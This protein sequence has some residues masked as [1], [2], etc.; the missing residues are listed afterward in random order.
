[1]CTN[2]SDRG[3]SNAPK[4]KELRPFNILGLLKI[5][6]KSDILAFAALILSL[7]NAFI[8]YDWITRKSDSELLEPNNVAIIG[9]LQKPPKEETANIPERILNILSPMTYI[10]TGD[11]EKSDIIE[12]ETVTISIP[13]SS[14]KATLRAYCYTDMD[15]TGNKMILY[16]DKTKS[17]LPFSVAGGTTVSHLS[18]FSPS[19]TISSRNGLEFFN[20][21]NFVDMKKFTDELTEIF[22]NKFEEKTA[23][24]KEAKRGMVIPIEFLFEGKGK[25]DGKKYNSQCTAYVNAWFIRRLSVCNSQYPIVS[26]GP[27]GEE[28]VIGAGWVVLNCF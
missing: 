22:K 23:I 15:G 4:E 16:S 18:H 24:S 25:E 8:A 9:Y 12:S 2:H 5:E 13:G 28:L 20:R 11:K 14:F 19:T 1:M 27:G 3:G 10:N 26:D 17:A 6:R 21:D 7:V